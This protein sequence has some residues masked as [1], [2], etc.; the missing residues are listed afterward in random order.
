MFIVVMDHG[1]RWTVS[2]HA[3]R[4]EAEQEIQNH[5]REQWIILKK[6]EGGWPKATADCIDWLDAGDEHTKVFT[7]D[8]GAGCGEEIVFG[9]PA[10]DAA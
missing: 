7:A 4:A 9:D 8:P 1:Y 5:V 3:T 2:L 10:Q 6:E